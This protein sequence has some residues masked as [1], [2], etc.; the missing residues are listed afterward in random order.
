[1]SGKK[2]H[3][4]CLHPKFLI[5]KF[6]CQLVDVVQDWEAWKWRSSSLWSYLFSLI[7][8]ELQPQLRVWW[9][10]EDILWMNKTALWRLKAVSYLDRGMKKRDVCLT[11]LN[12]TLH[13]VIG[14]RIFSATTML[15]TFQGVYSLVTFSLI[16]VAQG[17]FQCSYLF[18]P[19]GKVHLV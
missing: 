13:W 4:L 5:T 8:T 1:M 17:S 14:T 10:Y 9:I 11:Q 19:L 7:L 3:S 2:T 6:L 16:L 12:L 18:E 15:Q